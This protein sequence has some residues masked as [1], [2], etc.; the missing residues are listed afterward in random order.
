M[1]E[2]AATPLIIKELALITGKFRS[3]SSLLG[4][5]I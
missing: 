5:V 4:C 1:T 3:G 2:L